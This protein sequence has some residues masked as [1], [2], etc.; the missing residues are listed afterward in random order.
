MTDSFMFADEPEQVESVGDI[1]PFHILI[2]DDD[3]EIHVITKMALSEFKLDDRPL[4]FTSVYS[5]KEARALLES[6]NDFALMLLDVVMEDDHAGLDLVKWTREVLKNSMIRIVLR[7]GQPG[8]APEE[9]VISKYEIDD[10]KEKT[11]LTYRKLMTLMYSSL[12][13]F[14]DLQAIEKYKQGLERIIEASAEIF[15]AKSMSQLSQG[16]LEQLVALLTRSYSAAYYRVDGFTASGDEQHP[17]HIIAAT[18]DFKNEIGQSVNHSLDREII[19]KLIN[20]KATVSFEVVGNT[21]Y[22]VY[23]TSSKHFYLLYIR[24]INDLNE[25]DRKL[26]NMFMNNTAIAFEHAEVVKDN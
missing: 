8:Q 23:K 26:L 25:T 24:G 1:E 15:S 18:G 5:G 4:S 19:T 20:D 12:R 17:M 2:V 13:A 16:I 9:E 6:R 22:G 10:Y 11:E 14:R 3:E 7:T 21:Y